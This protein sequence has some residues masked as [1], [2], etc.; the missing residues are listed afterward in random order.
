MYDGS[1]GVCGVDGA[2]GVAEIG[3]GEMV[4]RVGRGVPIVVSIATPDLLVDIV[5]RGN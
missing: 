3:S 5:R 1:G 4:E 2:D